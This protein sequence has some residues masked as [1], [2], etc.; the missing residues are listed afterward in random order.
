M[1]AIPAA[2]AEREQ[3]AYKVHEFCTDFAAVSCRIE[4]DR[5]IHAAGVDAEKI[6]GTEGWMVGGTGIEPVTPTMST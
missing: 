5:A 6:I 2:C 1:A 4:P 3:G